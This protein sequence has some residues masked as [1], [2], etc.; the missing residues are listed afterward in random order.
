MLEA[1]CAFIDS[2]Q[3]PRP[4]LAA[5]GW[6]PAPPTAR[7]PASPTVTPARFGVDACRTTCASAAAPANGTAPRCRYAG[8]ARHLFGDFVTL[9]GHQHHF[10]APPPGRRRR[11]AVRAAA[12]GRSRRARLEGGLLAQ[13]VDAHEQ[14]QRPALGVDCSAWSPRAGA[15]RRCAAAFALRQRRAACACRRPRAR[16]RQGHRRRSRVARRRAEAQQVKVRLHEFL[17][18]RK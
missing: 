14:G 10:L 4:A 5:L 11:L 13:R 8:F 7:R 17:A 6:A 2:A 12:S 18:S 3:N 16:V 9:A 1:R 15:G